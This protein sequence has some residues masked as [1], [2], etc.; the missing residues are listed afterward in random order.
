LE[1]EAFPSLPVRLIK[2]WPVNDPADTETE[3]RVELVGHTCE[4]PLLAHGQR[5]LIISSQG[6][7]SGYYSY[8]YQLHSLGPGNKSRVDAQTAG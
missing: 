5:S 2:N 7:W 3:I 1:D 8:H 6:R 4:V